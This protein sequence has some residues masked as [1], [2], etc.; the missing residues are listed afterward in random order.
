MYVFQLFNIVK[1]NFGV[2][3]VE[4]VYVIPIMMVLVPF[5]YLI[6]AKL[7]SQMRS[8][9]LKSFEEELLQ[10]RSFWTQ[11]KDLFR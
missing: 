1:Q 3:E 6:R 11:I 4:I 10:K 8:D 5:V 2:D 9:D 7:F